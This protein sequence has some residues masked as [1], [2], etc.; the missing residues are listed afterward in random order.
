MPVSPEHNVVATGGDPAG[1]DDDADDAVEGEADGDHAPAADVGAPSEVGA[2]A[3]ANL[4]APSDD[5]GASAAPAG[6][7][8]PPGTS[9]GRTITIAASGDLLVHQRVIR[10]AAAHAEQGGFAHVL[11]GLASVLVED[12]IAFV[13]L[14]TPLA[15]TF[16]ALQSDFPPVLGAPPEVA[17][18][19]TGAGVDVVSVANNHAYDQTPAGLVASITESRSAGL[20]VIGGGDDVERA[21]EP[22][23]T[24]R[25]GV[26]IA[27]VAFA[28]HLNADAE[29]WQSVVRV[30]RLRDQRRVAASIER[31]RSSAD[32]VVAA[33]HWGA[34]FAT[35]PTPS[36]RAAARRLVDMGVDVIIGTGPHVLHEV[37]QMDSARGHAVVAY[38]LGNLV[39]NQGLK[40]APGRRP[41]PTGPG[42]H[43]DDPRP[44]DG[45][46][47]RVRASVPTAGR[48]VVEAIEAV[49]LWTHNNWRRRASGLER[50]DDVRIV[51]LSEQDDVLYASR[52]AAIAEALGP[53][54][55][56]M[57]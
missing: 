20:A 16:N 47:L 48:V 32:I 31:A 54:V 45:V 35:E 52:R 5:D 6:A 10:A 8:A 46:V 36:Q 37:E 23:V 34:D 12:E 9:S 28:D 33:V 49:P 30:A 44:R 53:F 41:Q 27:F 7:P 25:D 17:A 18:A 56:L 38:S 15:H 21:Y 1:N 42:D 19:L 24:E 2:D 51:R 50:V 3:L 29:R 39:S 55:R 26:R 14:E 13:N 11:S 22:W 40:W 4:E 43:D 57:P